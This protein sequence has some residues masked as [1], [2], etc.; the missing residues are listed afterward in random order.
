MIQAKLD[1]LLTTVVDARVAPYVAQWTKAWSAT[2]PDFSEGVSAL[3]DEDLKVT[4]DDAVGTGVIHNEL[5]KW[6]VGNRDHSVIN[7]INFMQEALDVHDYTVRMELVRRK[8]L[9]KPKMT[10][11]RIT[12]A[13]A[14][15][16]G[17]LETRLFNFKMREAPANKKCNIKAL[18]EAVQDESKCVSFVDTDAEGM[19]KI[20][21]ESWMKDMGAIVQEITAIVVP[22]TVNR[23]EELLSDKVL[24]AQLLKDADN[25]TKRHSLLF[26]VFVSLC[27]ILFCSAREQ[28]AVCILQRARGSDESVAVVACQDCGQRFRR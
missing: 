21:F 20:C 17:T 8:V 9:S 5:I 12:V 18:D 15:A 19:L 4:T 16:L 3:L 27:V 2:P 22:D 11:R 25:K 10:E 6:A 1:S 7:R 28:E 14:D 26:F 13:H 24:Q 23:K